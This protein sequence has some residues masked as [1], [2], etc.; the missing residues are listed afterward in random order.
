MW[1]EIEQVQSIEFLNESI[2]K[3]RAIFDQMSE[4]FAFHEVIYNSE[5][6]VVDYRIIDINPAFERHVGVSKAIAK[7][8]LATH[9]Y[10]ITPAPYIDI[11]VE[12]AE[13]GVNK[14][15]Q[16]Y[17]QPSNRHFEISVFSPQKGFFATVFSDVTERKLIAGTQEFLLKCGLPS[18]GE[19]YFKSM[20]RYLAETLRMDTI[21]IDRLEGD[22]FAYPIAVFSDGK[23]VPNVKYALKDTPCGKVIEANVCC[24]QRRVQQLFPLDEAL[25]ELDAESYYGTTLWDSKGIPIGL[26][27]VIG[28]KPM[29]DPTRAETLFKLIAPHAAGEMERRKAEQE[30]HE[31]KV[32]LHELIATKDKFFS[33]IAHD[34]RS[35]FNTIMGF[36]DLLVDQVK[37]KDYDGIERYAEI[38]QESSNSAMDLLVNLLEWSRIQTGR[39]IFNPVYTN[40]AVLLNETIYLLNETAKQKSIAIRIDS[41]EGLSGMVDVSMIKSVLRNLVSNAIKFTRL[42][43]RIDI[44]AKQEQKGILMFVKDNGVGIA[45]N[46]IGKLFRID[47]TY[48]SPGTNNE[49]GTGLGLILCRDFIEKHHGKIWVESEIGKGSTF[50]F[51]LPGSE[52]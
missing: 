22:G 31:S 40:I 25:H 29:E 18:T 42:G 27:A 28:H 37:E 17:F 49:R 5:N 44:V 20:A 9:V 11:Y 33:I 43:G 39:L 6:I 47:E 7:G 16:S 12:V 23:F 34:L 3:Y 15:F 46:G 52:K 36:S 30:L 50:Y 48:S 24:Y 38:I 14:L 8:G 51:S 21:C 10:G 32:Q 1:G 13:T 35:P 2:A 4:G 45:E 41:P 19:D 26:I